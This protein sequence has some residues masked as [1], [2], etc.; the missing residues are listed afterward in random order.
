MTPS[1]MPSSVLL[2]PSPLS[3][4]HTLFLLCSVS[5]SSRVSHLLAAL[6]EEENQNI[7]SR[8]T[9]IAIFEVTL[10]RR[11][12]KV[13]GIAETSCALRQIRRSDVHATPV[14]NNCIF[15]LTTR[16]TWISVDSTRGRLLNPWGDRGGTT[17]DLWTNW[18]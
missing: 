10:R 13:S 9:N 7:G 16:R 17:K 18:R 11:Y 14:Q 15:F 5:R 4:Q 8:R 3:K 2:L 12:G 1:L 6:G